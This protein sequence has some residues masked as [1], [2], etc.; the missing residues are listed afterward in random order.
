MTQTR[1]TALLLLP[2]T[3]LVLGTTW[4]AQPATAPSFAVLVFTK[5]TGFHHDSIT[6]GIAALAALGEAH[7]FAI[8]AT[9]DAGRF[10]DATLGRYRVV[11][12]L[13]TTGDVLGADQ[14]SAFERYIHGGGGF[15]GIHSASDTEYGWPWYGRLVGAF[16]ASHPEIQP[17]RVRI[18]DSGHPS[19]RDLPAN[20]L[21]TDEWYNFRSNPRGAVHLLA[22]LDEASYQGGTMGSDHPLAWCHD[23]EGGRAWYTAMGHTA[24]SYAEPLFRA[25][26][27]GGILTAAGIEQASCPAGP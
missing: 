24:D 7:G 8:D 19:T 2:V 10:T 27:L 16:F 20:W 23:F 26:L 3:L 17:A 13:N 1:S 18:V 6:D 25:H 12:F 14:K 22:T 9:E 5:T 21:R 11:I 4:S 15:V